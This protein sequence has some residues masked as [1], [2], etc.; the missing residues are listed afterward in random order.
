MKIF[1]LLISILLVSCA[2]QTFI[3]NPEIND[4]ELI[5]EK[6]KIDLVW[7]DSLIENTTYSFIFLNAIADITESNKI[8]ELKYIISTGAKIDSGKIYGSIYKYPE[9]APLENALIHAKGI[10]E[11]SNINTTNSN[12]N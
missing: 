4:I 2:Q 12:N 9:K 8:S 11:N 7:R 10:N 5:E 1:Y 6:N 3:T